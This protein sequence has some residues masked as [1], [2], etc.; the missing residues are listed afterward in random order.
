M[1]STP[2]CQ[3][4]DFLRYAAAQVISLP[5]LQAMGCGNGEEGLQTI[6]EW[7]DAR[8]RVDTYFA[9]ARDTLGDARVI[10][11]ATRIGREYV[12]VAV[13][14]VRQSAVE[15]LLAPLTARINDAASDEEAVTELQTLVGEDFRELN[16]VDVRGW[17][18]S[19]TEAQVAALVW[20]TS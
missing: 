17:T 4:R 18:L 13:T 8:P 5:L 20:L 16:I 2:R 6:P 11:A 3:R 9:D 10:E 19:E 14:P 15:D 12:N 1:S 7:L